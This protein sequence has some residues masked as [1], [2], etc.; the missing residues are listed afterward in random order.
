MI[1]RCGWT[2]LCLTTRPRPARYGWTCQELPP[3]GIAQRVI[4]VHKPPYHD[5]RYSL[6]I[7]IMFIALGLILFTFDLSQFSTEGFTLVLIASFLSGLRWT[8]AQKV[9]QKNEIGLSNPLDMMYHIQPW[10][11]LALL[12]LSASIE[13]VHFVASKHTFAYTDSNVMLTT[14]G[15][16]L[17]GAVLGFMLELSEFL[18]LS[19]TSGLTLTIAGILK[20]LCIMMLAVLVNGDKMS[21]VNILGLVIC[22]IGIS[23]HV[24]FKAV[25][26]N[27]PKPMNAETEILL[28]DG[29]GILEDSDE[30]EAE[31]ETNI[32][33]VIRDSLSHTV[34]VSS[35]PYICLHLVLAVS[36]QIFC[37]FH[38][39]CYIII[40]SVADREGVNVIEQENTDW[41]TGLT[42]T[43]GQTEESVVNGR[44]LGE[45]AGWKWGDDKKE[46]RREKTEK[47]EREKRG[48]RKEGRERDRKG[49]G[50]KREREIEWRE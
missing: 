36:Q 33:D 22:L 46:R 45:E 3:T 7:V 1:K 43:Q 38:T 41:N 8:L 15:I 49:K 48:E 16:I 50:R 27:E 6:V 11:M 24:I 17:V 40:I 34:I 31:D 25:H 21:A 20:E 18:L 44:K 5:K 47:G 28:Q 19:L 12:P 26:V 35:A 39:P 37:F 29:A 23:L 2:V 30:S 13:G 9:M 10:M 4:G 32:F 42:W 14:A